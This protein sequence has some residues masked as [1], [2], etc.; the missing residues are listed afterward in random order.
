M[1]LAALVLA[2]TSRALDPSVFGRFRTWP[3]PA[4]QE[5]EQPLRAMGLNVPAAEIDGTRGDGAV[6]L[7]DAL[8]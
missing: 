3:I 2:G 8:V 7:S 6:A 5:L 4:V 1:L